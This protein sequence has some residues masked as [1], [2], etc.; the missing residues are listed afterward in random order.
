M[1]PTTTKLLSILNQEVLTSDNIALRFSYIVEYKINHGQRFLSTFDVFQSSYCLYEAEQL[2]HNLTQV[3][4]RQ[5][6]ATINSEDLNN[7]R[8]EILSA[9]PIELRDRLNHS[10]IEIQQLTLRDITF[11]KTIQDLFAKQLEAKIRAKSDL[12]NARTAVATARTLKNAADLVKDNDN[13]K[14]FQYLETLAKIAATGKHTFV[15]GDLSTQGASQSNGLK[16]SP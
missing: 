14:F 2:I 3:H 9:V 1:L 8:H 12:E 5:A 10:G 13:I 4:I 15:I 16:N 11:P 6:I 7:Q